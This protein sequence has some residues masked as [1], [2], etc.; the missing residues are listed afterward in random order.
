MNQSQ[1]APLFV[2]SGA[3]GSGKT[4]LCR[5]IAN[6]L[7]LYYSVSYTT[8]E[9]RSGEKDKVDYHFVSR[10][11]FERMI[12]NNEFLEWAEVYGNF[13]GTGRSEINRHRHANHAVILDLDH[14][15]ALAIKSQCPEAILVIILAPSM[16][17]LKERL[18][19]RGSETKENLETRLAQAQVEE[20]Y[21]QHFDY[22][23]LNEDLQISY[24][25]L[26][27]I[28]E[29]HWTATRSES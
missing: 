21:Q 9:K 27:S 6:Q 10:T 19:H 5:M 25:T 15:G 7:G 18:M 4:T 13:Y 17:T 8:R 23:I 16:Q 11:E 28:I 14:Q 20:S 2:I 22:K 1:L 29:K 3:S 12:Q 26:E 24:K